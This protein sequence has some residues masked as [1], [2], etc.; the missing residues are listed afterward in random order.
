MKKIIT[1]LTICLTAITAQSQIG[2]VAP[3]FTQ[4]DINGNTHDLY[5]YLND[6]KVVVVDMSA[7]WCGPCWNFHQAHYLQ[8]LHDQFGPS[9]TDEAVIIFYEDD[10][11]TTLEDLNGT[12]SSTAGNWV[13]GVTYPIINATQTLPSQYGTGYPTISVICPTDKKIKDNLFNYST[14]D[15]MKTA[16]Q[17][18]ITDCGFSSID[19]NSEN[20]IGLIVSPNPTT[21]FTTIQFTSEIEKFATVSLYSV[22]GQLIST[23]THPVSSGSNKIE[24][25]MMGVQAGSYFVNIHTNNSSNKMIQIVKK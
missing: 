14:I 21:D 8:E 22:T 6:G 9:G 17:T 13:T 10:V 1:S 18:V 11:S 25:N 16:V 4:T 3:N 15:Q 24:L 12:G 20:L 19:E 5:N 7:T 2:A 23:T